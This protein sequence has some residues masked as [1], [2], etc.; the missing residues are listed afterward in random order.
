MLQVRALLR[1]RSV[2]DVFHHDEH[3]VNENLT[4]TDSL[5]AINFW[6]QQKTMCPLSMA[7]SAPL[8]RHPRRMPS[9]SKRLQQLRRR[10]THQLPN[11][12]QAYCDAVCPTTCAGPSCTATGACADGGCLSL[13]RFSAM[14]ASTTN[15]TGAAAGGAAADPFK[16][17][18]VASSG[19]N[20]PVLA[21]DGSVASAV[22]VFGYYAL[23][24]DRSMIDG[25]E[26]DPV[27]SEW[28]KHALCALGIKYDSGRRIRPPDD[29]RLQGQLPALR[30]RFRRAI[31]ARRRAGISYMAF[32]YLHVMLPGGTVLHDR[33]GHRLGPWASALKAGRLELSAS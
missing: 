31:R 8:H 32:S 2:L 21:G 26:E 25:S 11:A 6:K 14:A 18:T 13:G 17:R 30:R 4:A 22:A 19:M 29:A 7:R 1:R 24:D 27:A 20:G 15:W 16:I 5:R 12:S 28:E 3:V 23:N 9:A 10:R 33:H